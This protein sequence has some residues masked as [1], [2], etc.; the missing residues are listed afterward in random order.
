VE[1]KNPCFLIGFFLQCIIEYRLNKSSLNVKWSMY[2]ANFA[3]QTFEI[4]RVQV[5]LEVAEVFLVK[6]G[7]VMQKCWLEVLIKLL[8]LCL[9]ICDKMI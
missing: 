4:F 1:A 6:R 3:Y 9:H 5:G 8:I 7:Q 2:I